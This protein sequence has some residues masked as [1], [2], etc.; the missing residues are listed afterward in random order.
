[1]AHR[2]CR[3][4]SFLL[5]ASLFVFSSFA[6]GQGRTSGQ[7]SGTV[8]DPSGAAIP[9]ATVIVTQPATGFSQ[10]VTASGTGDYIFPDLQ[11]GTYSLKVSAKGFADTVLPDV[12]IATSRTTDL[13]VQMKVGSSSETVEVS[14]QAQTL[15]TTE[16]TLATTIDPTMIDNLPLNG[17]DLLE[18]ATLV[19][20]AANP[21]SQRYTTYNN[22]PN[23][24]VNITVNGTNDNFQRYRTFST[25]FFTAAPLREGA[26]EEATVATNDLTADAGAEGSAQIRFVTKSGTNSFHGRGFWQAQNS[27]FNANSYLNNSRNR[28]LAKSR[29][30]YY[31]GNLGGPLWRNRAF[32]F[33]NLEYHKR[34]GASQPINNVL[35]SD[36]ANGLYTYDVT[37][38]PAAT[39]SWVTCNAGA[40]TCTANLY[41]LAA[42]SGFPATEDATVKGILGQIAGYYPKGTLSPLATT[43]AALYTINQQYLQTLQ[44]FNPT[45]TTEWYPT[46][47]LDVNITPKIRWNDTWD[48]YWRNI[49]NVPN[50]PGS[51]YAGNGFKSTYYTWSNQVVWTISPS[52]LNT[53]SFGI[54]STV[55]EF[56]PGAAANP[57]NS[58]ALPGGGPRQV[59]LPLGI[60]T[61]VP[62][63]IL[64]VPRNNPS[65]NPSDMLTWTRGNHTFSLGGD[66]RYSNSHE[67]Q[68]NNPPAYNTGIASGDPAAGMF[69]TAN[70][71]NISAANGNRDLNSAKSL[72]AF[73]TGRISGVSGTNEV[74]LA[75]G[76]FAVQQGLVAREAQTVGGFYFQ[77]SWRTTPHLTLNYG[78]R[79]QMSSAV[80]NTNDS[81]F[82]P[83][84]QDLLGPS[85]TLFTPGVLNG[86]PNPQVLLRPSP[87]SGD[88]VQ[89]DPNFG[90]AWNPD[91]SDGFLGKLF[92]GTKTVIRGG[93]SISS[94]DEGWETFENASIYTNPGNFQ[95]V[96]Y[97]AGNPSVPGF[98]AAGSQLLSDPAVAGRVAANGTTPATFQTSLP[99]SLLTFTGQS[100]GTVDPNISTPYVE[101]WNLGIQRSLPGNF[102]VEVDYVGN[103]AVHL[104]QDYNLNEIN[105]SQPAFLTAFKN[106]QNNYNINA[107]NGQQTFADNT[108]FAGIV[109]TP[110]FDTAFNG[111]GVSTSATD[112]AGYAN[113]D[114]LFDLQTGQAG[115]LATTFAGSSQYLCNMVGGNF[116][117][118]GNVG[119]TAYPINFFEANPYAAGAQISVLSDPASSSYNALQISV[120]HPV[121]HGL[122]MGANYSFSKS[123]TGRFLS[124]FTDT[125][126]VNFISLRNP[127]LNKAPADNDMRHIFNVYWSYDLPGGKGHRFSFSNTVLNNVVGGWNLGG[128]LQMHS[129]IPFWF[130]GGQST[131]N[132][133][134]GGVVLNGITYSQIQ[135]A[136]GVFTTGNSQAPIDWLN[137]SLVN[138]PKIQPE[139]TPGVIGQVLFFHGPSYFNTDLALTK[140]IPIRESLHLVIKANFLNAFNHADWGVGSFG[141]PGY[142]FDASTQ[143]SQPSAILANSP[144]SIQFL[145]QL[146]F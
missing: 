130:Q 18:F 54:E 129:G 31:G 23:G 86:I 1:M 85:A 141:A 128:I 20:G 87:Y 42:A 52:M 4:G 89:P 37:S 41:S 13:K 10:T 58:M 115:A 15:T 76:H 78:F 138:S 106:A 7:L 66:L 139:S 101:S 107:A 67:L 50:W 142:I 34:P 73:L 104:W 109:A 11:P 35:T 121:G 94:Y 123:L 135:N 79:W 19:T 33:I 14:A 92:G 88:L 47:R 125:A 117:P 93:A 70:F 36:A 60:R 69:T 57:F 2:V 146:Q 133:E 45:K 131:F 25:G 102:A 48:L 3:I 39:P 26:F 16:N 136:V 56:N 122:S 49:A 97:Q 71:P 112:A 17:R 134:D 126:Q 120:R 96:S 46:T 62:S 75:T 29:D 44:F 21:D 82:D 64:P 114:F 27:F 98:F 95:V 91:F 32:F 100:Y 22:L 132:D 9:A 119:G 74:N 51:Q 108:G 80:H 84:Y 61:L 38:I 99:M 55:E 12:T 63:F 81:Y 137:P 28:P 105:A 90:F 6:W 118:C 143:L 53:A 40:Q 83:T 116:S 65:F 24:A 111:N 77:D 59:N 5:V 72:Y 110:L 103:H 43:P 30:N 140:N 145:T 127:G 8:I 68:I 144:R 124:Q 113:S